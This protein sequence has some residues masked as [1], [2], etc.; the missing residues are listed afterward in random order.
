[1]CAVGR[2]GCHLVSGIVA[3]DFGA[4]DRS[5]WIA[6]VPDGSVAGVSRA[7][8]V[9][10]RYA[11]SSS[12]MWSGVTNR[13]RSSA[14]SNIPQ[15]C[16]AH[17]DVAEGVGLEVVEEVCALRAGQVVHAVAELQVLH[18]LLKDVVECRAQ[19]AAKLGLL[20]GQSADPQ[21]DAVEA[22]EGSGRHPS[23]NS[24]RVQ[25]GKRS[26]ECPSAIEDQR[27]RCRA[28]AGKRGLDVMVACVP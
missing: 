19:H 11:T 1:M 23:V 28:L 16:V 25:E 10:L 4:E 26:A 9:G 15:R 13:R 6:S 22:T 21:V 20:L 17:H 14:S 8:I 12:M 27:F 5:D 24:S 18:L 3:H 2:A 7:V